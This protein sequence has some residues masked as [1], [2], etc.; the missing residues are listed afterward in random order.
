MSDLS[1]MSL[2]TQFLSYFCVKTLF[3]CQVLTFF[4]TLVNIKLHHITKKKGYTNNGNLSMSILLL[5]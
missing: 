2:S 5:L 1:Q 4:N 3:Q